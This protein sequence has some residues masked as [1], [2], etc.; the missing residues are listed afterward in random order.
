MR[1]FTV[2]FMMMLIMLSVST[3]VQAHD[4]QNYTI[5][6]VIQNRNGNSEI[7]LVSVTPTGSTNLAFDF[8]TTKK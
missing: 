1:S 8:Y 6:Q 2:P 5:M 4:P 7:T 3:N